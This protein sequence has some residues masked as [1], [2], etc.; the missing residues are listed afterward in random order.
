M[1]RDIAC[2]S[3][4]YLSKFFKGCL[5]QILIGPFLNAL[6]ILKIC[7][8]NLSFYLKNI[9]I[10]KKK[11]VYFFNQLSVMDKK[12][13][14]SCFHECP[15]IS[16][17]FILTKTTPATASFLNPISTIRIRIFQ[18]NLSMCYHE[19]DVSHHVLFMLILSLLH[20][21]LLIHWFFDFYCT[22]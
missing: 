2:L 4:P 9:I 20:I 1:G 3:R 8:K 16:I 5:P 7:P 13:N 17:Y 21:F 10:Q 12:K 14:F 11:Y 6:S 19:L 15:C 22:L 18:W